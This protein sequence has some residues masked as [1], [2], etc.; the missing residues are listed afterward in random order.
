MLELSHD[1]VDEVDSGTSGKHT[2]WNVVKDQ[3]RCSVL[4]DLDVLTLPVYG[5]DL[6][7]LRKRR[8]GIFVL[9]ESAFENVFGLIGYG[10]INKLA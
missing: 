1:V 7:L 5:L 6:Q 10:K 9:Q 4:T 8:T 3:S 2:H